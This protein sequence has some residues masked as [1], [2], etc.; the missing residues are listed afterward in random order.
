[1]V[2]GQ[3]FLCVTFMVKEPPCCRNVRRF[4]ARYRRLCQ[5]YSWVCGSTS[6]YTERRDSTLRSFL[7]SDLA[8]NGTAGNTCALYGREHFP[9]WSCPEFVLPGEKDLRMKAVPAVRLRLTYL[10]RIPQGDHLLISIKKSSLAGLSVVFLVTDSAIIQSISWP[11]SN[12]CCVDAGL[13][14]RNI[15]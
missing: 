13:L 5:F 14:Q 1:M 3:M 2:L 12:A 6:Q 4:P 15:H 11:P 9:S 8:T 7:S 10:L